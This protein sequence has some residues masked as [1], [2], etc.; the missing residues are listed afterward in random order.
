MVDWVKSHSYLLG[1]VVYKVTLGQEFH[2]ELQASSTNYHSINDPHSSTIRGRY[3]SLIWGQSTIQSHSIVTT[4]NNISPD[5]MVPA[6]RR[7][8]AG[9]KRSNAAQLY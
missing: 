1:S 5:N 8:V 9:L 2:Q 3:N 7:A 4:K 6:E